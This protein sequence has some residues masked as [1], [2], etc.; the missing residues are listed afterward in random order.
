MERVAA[1]PGETANGED[2]ADEVAAAEAEGEDA[3][4][5][6]AAPEEDGSL[7]ANLEMTKRKHHTHPLFQNFSAKVFLSAN[8]FRFFFGIV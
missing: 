5:A 6:P 7:I 4:A 2:V 3:A 1:P 8:K